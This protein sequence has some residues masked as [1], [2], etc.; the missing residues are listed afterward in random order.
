M[1]A[2]TLPGHFRPMDRRHFLLTAMGTLAATVAPAP[3]EEAAAGTAV[4][5]SFR[6]SVAAARPDD[7]RQSR[8]AHRPAR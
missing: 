2:H 7:Q 8:C 1:A 4:S 6:H 5:I 3:V